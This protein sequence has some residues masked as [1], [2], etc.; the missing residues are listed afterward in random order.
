MKNIFKNLISFFLIFFIGLSG[1]Y[2]IALANQETPERKIIVFK[3]EKLDEQLKG[4]LIR[5]VGGEKI[6]DLNLINGKAVYLTRRAQKLIKEFPEVLRVEDDLRVEA[7]EVEKLENLVK[8]LAKIS[9]QRLPWGVDRI[10]A[11]LV[12]PITK[13]EGIKV[14][15]VDTGIDLS[16]PDLK[17]NIKGGYSA[18]DYTKSYNDDNGHGTHVAG[19]V[20][21]GD[22]SIGVIGVGP[23][24]NLYGV[25][26]LNRSG[27]GYLSDVIEG[28]EWVVN[29]KKNQ[30]GDWVINMSL[31]T[32]SYSASFEEA[33]NKVFEAGIIQ[34]A[35][36]G[37]S[38]PKDNTVLYP[39]KFDKVIAVSAIDQNENIASWSSR[40]PEIDLCAPGVNIY[41]TYR[42]SSYKT[43]SGTSMAAPHVTGVVALLLS[44]KEKCQYLLDNIEG[45]SPSEVQKR[46]ED[47]AEQLKT[48]I[49]P[50]KDNLFGAGLVDAEA[51]LK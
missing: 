24:I 3:D 2:F 11:D 18:V 21:A 31:G 35:A 33:I 28:L 19:I 10:D 34:V 5:K 44:Y 15:I 49:Y 50:G 40:G 25:K 47:T 7:L 29:Q 16:H 43:L 39:A 41:S 12:W 14:A 1:I 30:G 6:K 20:A 36:A 4:E 48:D 13:A 8:P 46:L 9:F 38:G 27:S 23:K 32:S 51:V 26:V 22:N 17:E 42:G 45:C 37:N